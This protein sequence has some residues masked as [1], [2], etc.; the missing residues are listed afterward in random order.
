MAE[1]RTEAGKQAKMRYNEGYNKS[2]YDNLHIRVKK[3]V[4]DEY[5]AAAD[6]L[7]LSLAGLVTSAVDDYISKHKKP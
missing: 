5:K 6:S 2:T 3:G 7:G 1:R 4:R